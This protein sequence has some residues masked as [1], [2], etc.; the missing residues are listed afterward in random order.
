MKTNLLCFLMGLMNIL[1]LSGCDTIGSKS[2]SMAFIYIVT[3]LISLL[4]LILYCY[5]IP[6]KNM[7]FL[8]LFGSILVVNIGYLSL[9]ISKSLEEALLANRISYLGSVFLP[10]AMMMIILKV[11]HFKYPKWLP[12][13]LLIIGIAVFLIAASPG[14]LDIYYKDVTGKRKQPW[15]NTGLSCRGNKRKADEILKEYSGYILIKSK[16]W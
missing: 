6:K 5:M 16:Q 15:I 13:L 2:T 14:Y 4:V 9:A 11:I 3:T 1:L 12:G 10:M 8:L 7:W